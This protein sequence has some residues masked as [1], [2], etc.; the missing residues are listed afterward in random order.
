MFQVR[1]LLLALILLSTQIFALP[2]DSKE[3]I[4]I[5]A[6]SW[7]YNYKTGLTTYIGNVKADQGTTHITADKLITK[8]NKEHK[9]E[10]AVAYGIKEPAHYWTIPKKDDKELHAHAM[11]I[12]FYPLVS[13]VNMQKNVIITQGDNSFNGQI[14]FYNMHDETITVPPSQNGRA[15]IVYNPEN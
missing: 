6:D 8:S 12:K 1:N 7:I 5:V 11:I 13:N 15:T 4:F 14:I 3:K 9:I 2:E 10:E